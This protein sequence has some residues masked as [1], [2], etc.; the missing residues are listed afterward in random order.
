[1]LLMDKFEIVVR[2]KK[3]ELN[4]KFNPQEASGFFE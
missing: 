3:Y 1:M 2:T 4:I